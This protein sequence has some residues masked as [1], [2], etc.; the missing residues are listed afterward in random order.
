MQSAGLYTPDK[1]LLYK[2]ALT[3]IYGV[4][5]VLAKNLISYCGGASEIFNQKK[6]KLQ[7]I[8]GIGEKTAEAIAQFT[9]FGRVEEELKFIHKH[10]I[11]PL[12]YLDEDYPERLKHIADAPC[13]LY[14][15]GNADLNTTKIVGIVGTRKCTEYGKHFVDELVA[16]LASTGAL[17]VSGLALGV[18]VQ[19]HRAALKN[20][21]PTV[22]VVAHGLDRV[23]PPQNTQVAKRMIENGGLLTEYLSGTNPDRE[24]FPMRNRIVAGMCDV[25]IVVETAERGGAM[26]T[27]ELANG[28]NKE[29]MALP[30]RAGDAM[31]AGCNYLIKSNK[32]SIV[33]KPSDVIEWMGWAEKDTPKQIQPVLPL[34][35]S[36]EEGSIMEHLRLHKKASLDDMAFELQMN[37]TQLSMY[38]LNLEMS[39]LIRTLP[40]KFYE[41]V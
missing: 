9:D 14:Y 32:A 29:V 38:L 22:G 40:G 37:Q 35:I 19:A 5:D 23:Y 6:Q 2:I 8:P 12:F 17:V 34:D 4:G 26:I 31:S 39:G 41:C 18:D 33:T 13:M 24:N 15:L 25:L 36:T 10:K 16:T 3:Q 7:R 1:D 30:G 21:L 27:A 28:Y 20:N 11:K